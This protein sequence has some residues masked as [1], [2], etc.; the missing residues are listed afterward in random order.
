MSELSSYAKLSCAKAFL[1]YWW[2]KDYAVKIGR[3][4]SCRKTKLMDLPDYIGNVDV[5]TTLA[6]FDEVIS[7]DHMA[8]I[9]HVV[10]KA[11][12]CEPHDQISS[13]NIGR[14]HVTAYCSVLRLGQNAIIPAINASNLRSTPACSNFILSDY[15]L[16]NFEFEFKHCKLLQGRDLSVLR[17]DYDR[18]NAWLKKIQNTFALIDRIDS[19][20]STEN[21]W[22]STEVR[23][24]NVDFTGISQN[25]M[26]VKDVLSSEVVMS[27]RRSSKTVTLNGTTTSRA[28]A[29]APKSRQQML[30]D[31]VNDV[32]L[33]R[34]GS[35]VSD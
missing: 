7:R 35:N 25:T 15:T 28:P 23:L 13:V 6:R 4:K 9:A 8:N 12:P 21:Y 34:R 27:S 24:M 14:G 11:F 18:L 26:S 32:I 10:K 29:P 31:Y 17:E 2:I 22:Y 1:T 16:S 33:P 19:I 20:R 3:I 5:R 30:N